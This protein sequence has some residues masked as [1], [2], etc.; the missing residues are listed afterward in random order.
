MFERFAPESREAV[1]RAV[2]AARRAGAERVDPEHLLL[3]LAGCAVAHAADGHRAPESA[4]RP[5]AEPPR[6]LGAVGRALGEAGIDA[7]GIEEAIERAFV[8]ALEVVGVP[9]SVVASAPIRPGADDPRFGDATKQA[10][11]HALVHAQRRG[12]RRLGTAHLLLGLLDPPAAGV[13]RVL[14]RLD[15]PPRRLAALVQVELASER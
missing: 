4:G 8:A 3:A 5:V 15:V 12:A 7:A 10:L 9:A 6:Q 2:E 13:A 11:A 14:E 1:A